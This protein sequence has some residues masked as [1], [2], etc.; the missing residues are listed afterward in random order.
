LSDTIETLP[1]QIALTSEDFP[2]FGRPTNVTNPDRIT[3]LCLFLHLLGA[4]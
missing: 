4:P 2:T 3:P 1:P